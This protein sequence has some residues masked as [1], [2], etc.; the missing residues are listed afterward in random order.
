METFATACDGFPECSGGVDE[1]LCSNDSLNQILFVS[2]LCIALL[3]LVITFGCKAYK[4]KSKDN[5]NRF[6]ICPLEGRDL[7]K[8]ILESYFSNHGC[9]WVIEELNT[10]L[11]HIILTK[12]FDEAKSMCRELYVLEAELHNNDKA[13]IFSC[14]HQNLDPLIMEQVLDSQFPGL[15]Q[16][17]IDKIENC[18]GKRWIT[19]LNDL[20]KKNEVLMFLTKTLTKLIKIELQYLDILKDS[21]LAVSLYFIVGY[22]AISDY[23]SDF[24]VVVVCCL[25]T[26]VVFP[27]VL[28]TLHLMV[29]NPYIIFQT[30]KTPVG[31]RKNLMLTSCWLLS[32]LNPIFLLSAYEEAK[33]DTR[34]MAKVMADNVLLQMRKTRNVKEQWLS[35]LRIELGRQYIH[36]I[37]Q[38]SFC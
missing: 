21:Y 3:Y 14:L 4:L 24:L 5:F 33:E 20:F 38:S 16:L 26:L 19:K 30:Y 17:C 6:L 32:F 2:F 31:W 9:D 36:F 37:L 13:E 25:I 18:C 1:N 23:P 10:F 27:L 29:N 15:K 22:Q 12:T 35:F 11:L 7:E 8:S 34:I 28:A